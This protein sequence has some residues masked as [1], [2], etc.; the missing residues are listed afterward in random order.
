M[1]NP[2]QVVLVTATATIAIPIR[3]LADVRRAQTSGLASNPK[4]VELTGK[5][6]KDRRLWAN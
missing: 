3:G 1:A 6:D 4:E 2:L 5:P